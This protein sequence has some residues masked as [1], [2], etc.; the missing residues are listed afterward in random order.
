MGRLAEIAADIEALRHDLMVGAS[1]PLDER[2]R[3]MLRHL[4]D[5]F[6]KMRDELRKLDKTFVEDKPKPKNGRRR[7]GPKPLTKGHDPW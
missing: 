5:N 2:M 7:R 6:M 4:H 3:A 1:R